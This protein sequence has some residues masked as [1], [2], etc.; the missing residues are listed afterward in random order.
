MNF[1]DKLKQY[2]ELI[3]KVGINVQKGQPVVLR[4]PIEAISLVNECLRI[5]YKSGASD[6]HVQW[7]SDTLTRSKYECSPLEN[8]KTVKPF[9]I[10]E[11]KYYLEKGAGFISL[12]GEDPELLIGIDS[13]IIGETIQSRS[14]VLKFFNE[15]L[16]NDEIP[17]TVAAFPHEKW[18]K[19]IFP[20]ESTEKAVEKLWEAIFDCCRIDSNTVENWNHH[21]THLESKAEELNS[22][23][24]HSLHYTASNG[25]DLLIELPE[26]H[27][28]AGARSLTP[29][30]ISFLANIPTEE[31]Y[32]MPK[33]D[34][35]NGIVYSSKPLI[36]S[37][38]IIDD[39]YL[40]FESGKVVEAKAKVGDDTLQE[41]LNTDEG[42]RSLGEVAIVPFDSPISNRNLLFYNTLFDENA[43]CHLA[44]GEAY[45][46]NIKNG[47]N[48]TKEEKKVLG[49][50]QSLI[51][52]DFM[53]GTEDLSIMGFTQDKE[54][55]PIFINGNWAK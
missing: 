45:P 22:L 52:E 48:L 39:F 11:L 3:V 27:I 34:G 42:S 33:C 20:K 43:S 41:M 53:I 37:G 7:R 5:A 29:Q 24:L 26:G 19:K 32:S 28:W 35:V 13:E 31:V 47:G 23:N 30:G 10:E 51:H 36:Y 12:T 54:E 14:K 21:L 49:V 50:N 15:K 17:W 46:T 1:N 25:T 38:N 16:M 55:I 9:E 6:V 8:L 4:A 2:A 18:A 40:R 44:L